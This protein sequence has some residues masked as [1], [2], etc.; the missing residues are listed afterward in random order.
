M[1]T[2]SICIKT[3]SL[4][5]LLDISKKYNAQNQI[6]DWTNF[7]QLLLLLLFLE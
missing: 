4:K 2:D 1:K 3:D 5:T 6:F 7:G